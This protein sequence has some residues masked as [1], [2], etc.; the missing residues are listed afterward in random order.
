MF[1]MNTAEQTIQYILDF[2]TGASVAQSGVVYY[3]H[4]VDAPDCAKVVVVPAVSNL[5]IQSLPAVPFACLEGVPVL[6]GVVG[7]ERANGKIVVQADIVASAFFLLSRYEEILKPD[8]RDQHGRFLAK[9]S[10]VFQQGYGARPL[11]DEY[12]A[13]LRKWLREAGAS[14][15]AE[16]QGFSAVYLTHD[17]DE[18]FKFPRL[19]SVVKQYVKNILHYHYS[20][21]PLKKYIHEEYDEQNTFP[22]IINYDR[23]LKEKLRDIP[24]KSI[25]F[26]IS[27]GSFFNRRY[28]SFFS[29][30]TERLINL[31]KAS[32]AKL[33]LHISCEAG[34]RPKRINREANRL[35]RK[36]G[37]DTIMSRHHFLK[38]REPENVAYMEQAGVTADFTLT[39]ADCAGFRVGTCRP[40]CFI[41]PGTKEL[42]SVV[43]HP[44]E[45]MDGTLDRPAYMDLDYERALDK[46]RELIDQVYNHNGE[47]VLLWHNTEFLGKN[48]QEDL[49]KAVLGYIAQK[50]CLDAE[51]T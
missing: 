6:F 43:I 35:K 8:C 36:S 18:P 44:L 3:G 32:G 21:S 4:Q 27:A 12:G 28:Y 38:W 13:L 20:P 25:Y 5:D 22:K 19:T 48:Y 29:K 37:R 17:V 10:V 14:V 33:G 41:N 15:P 51:G 16:K 49:Y 30:K 1:A 23:E 39:Y 46:C 31:L 47:L 42:T 45:I 24:V 9:D 7:V 2:L 11:V 26:L 40:Y 34:A 50:P